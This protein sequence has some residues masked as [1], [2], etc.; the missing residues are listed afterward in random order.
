MSALVSGVYNLPLGTVVSVTVEAE[1][2]VG[3]SIPSTPNSVGA[4]IKTEP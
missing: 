4:T 3:Y 1:N 2:S